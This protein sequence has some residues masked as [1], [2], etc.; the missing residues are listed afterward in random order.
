MKIKIPE[1]HDW[2]YC[3]C[4][5]CDLFRA[6]VR[7]ERQKRRKQKGMA[8]FDNAALTEGEG[9]KVNRMFAALIMSDLLKT[10]PPLDDEDG[11]TIP[12]RG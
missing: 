7:E 11:G 5:I 4:Q 2:A 1:G 10:P 8:V 12:P 9:K 3:D 6:E